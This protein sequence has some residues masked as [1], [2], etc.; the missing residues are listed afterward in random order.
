LS[1][2]VI[3]QTQNASKTITLYSFYMPGCPHCERLHAYMTEL[4]KNY[5]NLRIDEIDVRYNSVLFRNIQRQYNV[6]EEQ[7]NSV[8]KLFL[9]N[10]SWYCVGDVPCIS[11]VEEAIK[12]AGATPLP[13]QPAQNQTTLVEDKV[14]A[15]KLVLLAFVDSINPCE[16]AI[17]VI[18]L[19]SILLRY[20][21]KKIVALKAGLAFTLAIIAVYFGFGLLLI[22]GFKA[23][24]GIAGLYNVWIYKALGVF[25]IIL[26]ILNIKDFFRYGAGGFVMEVPMSWRPKMKALIEAT[27][28]PRG[29]FV[30]GLFCALFLTPCTAGP[31]FVAGGILAGIE[32]TEA[33]PWL[34]LYNL[35]FVLPMLAIVAGVYGGFTTVEHVSSWREKNIRRL[36]LVA[37]I[38]LLALG[39]AIVSGLI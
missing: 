3:A 31:Y 10:S 8:P 25:A 39:V 16:L 22:G 36:H 9:L 5:T 14:T 23:A 33:L 35:I 19:T 28:S 32:W 18:L 15:G 38:I 27:T 2:I 6:P 29:A 13:E 30:V 17:L 26:G 7:W 1:S 20:P 24:A 11:S 12:S 4:Q 34:V 21:N 37:G